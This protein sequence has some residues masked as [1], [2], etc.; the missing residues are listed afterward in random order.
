M[1]F[2]FY[3]RRLASVQEQRLPDARLSPTLDET[4]P[5]TPTSGKVKNKSLM[6]DS[7]LVFA[8]FKHLVLR[9]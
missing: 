9:C 4:P 2:I 5:V 8:V 3:F 7:I 1:F 6:H